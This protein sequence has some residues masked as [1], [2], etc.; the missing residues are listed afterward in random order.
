MSIRARFVPFLVLALL[1][2]FVLP[3][4]GVARA[5]VV[6][7]NEFA[8]NPLILKNS[9]TG[10][11]VQI[12]PTTKWVAAHTSGSGIAATG[13]ALSTTSAPAGA[14]PSPTC[15][16]ATDASP[17]DAHVLVNSADTQYDSL[18]MNAFGLSS[19]ASSITGQIS[20][21]SLSNG[22][23]VGGTPAPA[24]PQVAGGADLWYV[25]WNY[26]S[27]PGVKGY[28]LEAAVPRRAGRCRVY[29]QRLDIEPA[30]RL[31]VGHDRHLGDRRRSVHTRWR[32]DRKLRYHRQSHHGH[33]ALEQSRISRCGS[34]S[35]FTQGRG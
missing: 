15:T 33:G 3:F 25:I 26:G 1:T 20:T 8:T 27:A 18:D 28:F 5:D 23:P 2:V 21:E 13:S 24:T 9:V 29:Q 12:M 16:L 31:P 14:L 4:R 34:G 11:Q 35:L 10:A 30:R 22:T 7:G 6:S 19:D 17:G 32:R